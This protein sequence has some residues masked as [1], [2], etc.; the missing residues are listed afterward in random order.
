MRI[1]TRWAA[2]TGALGL[3]LAVVALRGVRRGR[4]DL[5]AWRVHDLDG[6]SLPSA[7]AFGDDYLDCGCPDLCFCPVAGAV[8]CP[9]HSGFSVCCERPADHVPLRTVPGDDD[10]VDA[11]REHD[12]LDLVVDS[13][14]PARRW[15]PVAP[16]RRAHVTAR[17]YRGRTVT[18]E[19]DV[20]GRT[21]RAVL[22]AQARDHGWPTWHAWVGVDQV[23]LH[24][25]R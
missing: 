10:I 2:A 7:H 5:A 14:R 6:V 1:A 8:E 21:R 20:V 12:W 18:L 22:V 13:D 17:T 23:V 24:A 11:S 4:D 25:R 9:R 15:R 19:L 16:P 3:V